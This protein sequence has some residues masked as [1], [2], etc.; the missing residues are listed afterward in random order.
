MNYFAKIIAP[1]TMLLSLSTACGVVL[2]DTNVDKALISAWSAITTPE[3]SEEYGSRFSSHPH[4]HAERVSLAGTLHES[5]AHPRTAPRSTDRKHLHQKR[6]SRGQGFFDGY[7][8]LADG[9]RV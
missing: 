6:V 2:H 4:T 3:S 7:R 1:I 5:D 9:L 8:L